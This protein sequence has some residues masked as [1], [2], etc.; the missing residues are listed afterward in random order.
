MMQQQESE[1]T[2]SESLSPEPISG[3]KIEIESDSDEG[4]PPPLPIQPAKPGGFKLGLNLGGLGMST[5]KAEGQ[6][7]T[8]E[9]LAD[10]KQLKQSQA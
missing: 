7:M 3:Q 10:L 4:L 5:L 8:N 1:D 6:N 2:P 9:E